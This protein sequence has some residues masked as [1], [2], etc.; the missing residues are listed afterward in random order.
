MEVPTRC[1]TAVSS[2]A[3]LCWSLVVPGVAACVIE[4]SVQCYL[5]VIT[6]ELMLA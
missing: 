3:M 2:N 1:D 6:L 4:L 5:E